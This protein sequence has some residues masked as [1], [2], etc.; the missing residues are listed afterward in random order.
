MLKIALAG[1]VLVASIATGHASTVVTTGDITVTLGNP[2]PNETALYLDLNASTTS[3]SG[4]VG[5]QTGLPGS[6]IVSFM[7]NVNA[8]FANGVADISA[9][10][11][12]TIGSLTVSVPTGWFFTDLEF[13]TL[14]G[15][16]VSLTAYNGATVVGTY[17]NDS[18]GNGLEAFLLMA[19]NGKELTSLV[20]ASSDGFDELKQFAISGLQQ[21][22]TVNCGP[23]PGPGVT[24]LPGALAMFGSAMAAAAGIGGW[25]RRRHRKLKQ[26]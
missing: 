4:H 18:I 21:V 5:S 12:S 17:S 19:I 6:P 9:L 23:G 25:R 16:Q 10:Q 7:T 26:G 3:G 11:N 20:I 22:C 8:K 15:N 13:S 2:Q 14:K 24:P 1:L